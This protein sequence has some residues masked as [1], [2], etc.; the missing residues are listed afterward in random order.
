MNIDWKITENWLNIGLKNAW[1]LT[2]NS[3]KF[4]EIH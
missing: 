2:K 4:T 1:K 3:L